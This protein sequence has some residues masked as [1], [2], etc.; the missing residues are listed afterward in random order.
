MEAQVTQI[1]DQLVAVQ[2]AIESNAT[3]S[4]NLF[5]LR[6][7]NGLPNEDINEWLSR[8]EALAKFN[9]WS[10]AK[11]LNA[12]SLSLGGAAKAWYDAQ[13]AETVNDLTTLINALKNRFGTQT[14]EFLFRQ[15]LFARKQGVNEPLSIYTE[16][17]LRKGQRI[18]LSDKD[19]MN[20]FI[21]GLSDEIK[22]HVILNQPET[23]AEAENLARL[24]DAVSKS[25]KVSNQNTAIQNSVQEQRIK[26]LESQVNLLVSLAAQK[27]TS[28]SVSQPV[29]AI[30][31]SNFDSEISKNPFLLP[32]APERPATNPF[33]AET[34]SHDNCL[35]A[36]DVISLMNAS[37]QNNQAQNRQNRQGSA[38]GRNL[39]TR[40]GR[41][42][43]NRCQGIGHVARNCATPQ[44]QSN[45]FSPQPPRFQYQP[46][47][48][49]QQQF[50][51]QP[52]YQQQPQFQPQQFQQQPQFQNTQQQNLNE[53][54]SS[55]WGN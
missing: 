6:Q 44:P 47:F 48:N 49:Q 50:R 7:F 26:E 13:T 55:Q 40:D 8:F 1:R 52:R 23:F 54:G 46:R 33:K 27:T 41:P 36:V 11:R 53:M 19:I 18:G 31:A 51:P 21:S 10:N 3:Q 15:E 24:R 16:D 4:N 45:M 30:A 42:I 38:R 28:N 25:G 34:N 22:N 20:I 5:Q 35:K 37:F 39:R 43:C 17:I 9:N 2:A 12:V 29:Q 14:L 32:S